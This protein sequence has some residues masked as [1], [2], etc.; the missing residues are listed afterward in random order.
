[1][2]LLQNALNKN[3]ATLYFD[4][5]AGM[6]TPEES[7]APKLTGRYAILFYL[8]FGVIYIGIIGQKE[9]DFLIY[10]SASKDLFLHKD[11]YN[12]GYIDGYRYYYSLLF[13]ILIY[14]LSFI[15]FVAAKYI[16]ITANA[17]LLWKT[18]TLIGSYFKL[19]NLPPKKQ[20]LFVIFSCAFSANFA[21]SN[22]YH[23]QITIL[24]LFLALKGLEYI[25]SGKSLQGALM[26]ALGINIKLLPLVLLPYL[27]YRRKFAAV[28]YT[29]PI[30]IILLLLPALAIG[31]Q[32]NNLL[33]A[34]WWHL[35][36]PGNREHIL[37][38]SQHGFIS[39]TSLLSS[40]LVNVPVDKYELHTRRNIANLDLATLSLVINMVRLL[41]IAFTLYFLR[42]RP[43][44]G[45]IT[46]T[47][48]F[49]EISY[50]LLIT[51][52]LF[53]HQQAYSFFFA[54]PAMVWIFFYYF[55]SYSTMQRNKR[56]LMTAM[57]AFSFL[58]VNASF[59]L[60]EY[61][62]WYEHYKIV[63]YGALALVPL[64]AMSVPDFSPDGK[65][66]SG[67]A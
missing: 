15:P 53:P 18:V 20:W 11:I 2:K 50:V 39:L 33:L 32:E 57:L 3:T 61:N 55:T 58:T 59:L 34:G 19:Q 65:G 43:F 42:T 54:M 31:L 24:V 28:L 10:L 5:F 9:G 51:P 63:A 46:R 25:F 12:T 52:L 49:W 23:Q 37:D 56:N 1:M 27:I 17:L 16:W 14:P 62:P 41:F 26:L 30:Y 64:L 6:I 38:V 29:V 40:L 60:G 13:A 8:L 22:I 35:V 48:R 47:H 7:I 67:N 45:K 66:N 36:N 44:F 4:I 21:L